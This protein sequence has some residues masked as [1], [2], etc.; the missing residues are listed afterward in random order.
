MQAVLPHAS[1]QGFRTPY[2]RPKLSPVKCSIDQAEGPVQSGARR[3]AWSHI[4]HTARPQRDAPQQTNDPTHDC[5]EPQKRHD[6]TRPQSRGSQIA[7]V[8]AVRDGLGRSVSATCGVHASATSWVSRPA[9][10]AW[11]WAPHPCTEHEATYA[12]WRPSPLTSGAAP[13]RPPPRTESRTSDW[14]H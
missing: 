13:R 3:R 9:V 6:E 2:V 12:H 1:Y 10:V 7:A 5:Q 11:R 4:L 8:A 14:L